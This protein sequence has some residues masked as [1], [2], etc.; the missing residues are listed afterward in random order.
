MAV[1][2]GIGV[3]LGERPREV[4][5]PVERGP[6]AEIEVVVL[7]VKQHGIDSRQFG[8]AD[9]RGRESFINIGIVGRRSF[10]VFVQNA[11]QSE[12]AQ[13]VFHGRIGL[14]RHPLA[15]AVD[16]DAGDAGHF[17]LLVRLL[18]DDRGQH[19]RL[20]ARQARAQQRLIA[21]HV[22]EI[23]V[24]VTHA[25]DEVARRLGPIGFVR[26]GQEDHE[27]RKRIEIQLVEHLRRTERLHPGGRIGL[28]LARQTGRQLL[29]GADVVQRH[30][31]RTLL[32]ELEHAGHLDGRHPLAHLVIAGFEPLFQ[33]DAIGIET[34]STPMAHAAHQ[35]ILQLAVVG[36]RSNPHD[37][38]LGHSISVELMPASVSRSPE[39]HGT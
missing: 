4:V 8:H 30:L 39:Q 3:V 28:K 1:C 18:G 29:L 11:P 31:N 33:P 6:G 35:R 2:P 5:V 9:H 32:A 17:V 20:L 15:Q 16:V 34:E 26:V 25:Q 37:K 21:F 24:V 36:I 22:P 12:V 14:E 19:H 13:R 27:D 23:V 10:Q 38:T 7:L